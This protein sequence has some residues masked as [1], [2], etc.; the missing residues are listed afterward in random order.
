MSYC[1]SP[2]S[3]CLYISNFIKNEV[4]GKGNMPS[5]GGGGARG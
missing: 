2:L 3:G 1:H 5:R 4:K